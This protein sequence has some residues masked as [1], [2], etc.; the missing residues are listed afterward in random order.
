MKDTLKIWVLPLWTWGGVHCHVDGNTGRVTLFHDLAQR[1]TYPPL[2]TLHRKSTKMMG[3]E[4]WRV[5][6]GEGQ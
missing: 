3:K 2:R 1:S 6:G 4:G 5:K